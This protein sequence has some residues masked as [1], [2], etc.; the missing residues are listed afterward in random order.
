[1]KLLFPR[2]LPLRPLFPA[3]KLLA[4]FFSSN[5]GVSLYRR[6]SPV[7]DPDVSVV[8]I[9]DQ[10]IQEGRHV[11]KEELQSIIKELRDYKRFKHALEISAWMSEKRYIP[12]SMDDI[13]ARMNLISRVHG[14][15]QVENYFNNIPENM[16]G[17]VVYTALLN[18][19]AYE[20]SVEKAELVMQKI[21]D[22]GFARKPLCYNIL[23]NMYYKIGEH[24]KLDALVLKMEEKGINPDKYTLSIRLSAYAAISDVE[25]I[26]KTV[27]RMESDPHIVLDWKPYSIAASGYLKVGLLDKA[28]EM[29]KKLEGL[30]VNSKWSS[31]AFD[32]LL[33]LYA[34]MGKKDELYRIWKLYK[35]KG[36][37]YNKG[38]ISMIS[39]LLAFDDIEGAEKIFE[40]WESMKLTCDF[41]VPKLM[42]DA[43]CR[44]GLLAKAEALV[45][46]AMTKG[47]K[48]SF[49]SWYYLSCRYLEDN[50]ISKALETM[51]KAVALCP[52]GCKPNKEILATCLEYLE[53]KG[54]VEGADKFIDLL[55]V[56]GIF[57]ALVHDRLLKYIK[58]L[59]SNSNEPFQTE[60]NILTGDSSF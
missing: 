33:K 29:V 54:N 4:Y 8:P 5:A 32:V 20:K 51:R 40:E 57:S 59:K 43:Y 30:I 14:L 3:Q 11:D 38:Y 52:P 45:N 44:K 18:C 10:W 2:I 1:M 55:R 34:E 35:E 37:I 56:E 31:I 49:D 50:E 46:K 41:R 58:D 16:K 7:G 27:E 9:L 48:P 36:K 60:G 17:F 53:G 15:E 21:I 25:E 22:R 47:G 28:L 42:I 13:A 23:I 24:E 26:S 6:I 19:C 12:L 39:S